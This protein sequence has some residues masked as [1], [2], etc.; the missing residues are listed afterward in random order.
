MKLINK[1]VGKVLNAMDKSTDILD[2][3]IKILNSLNNHNKEAISY[4]KRYVNKDNS[5]VIEV[6]DYELKEDSYEH[7]LKK[8]IRMPIKCKK[9]G[10]DFVGIGGSRECG[11]KKDT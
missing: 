7:I 11:C 6:N 4:L 9:C 5:D 1:L 10:K 2:K 8:N 3:K